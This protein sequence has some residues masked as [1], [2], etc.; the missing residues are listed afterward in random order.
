[1][2]QSQ[3]QRQ[4]QRQ[5]PHTRSQRQT[6]RQAGVQHLDGQHLG[7]QHLGGHAGAQGWISAQPRLLSTPRPQQ[8]PLPT[9]EA[10]QLTPL[11]ISPTP[12][13]QQHGQRPHLEQ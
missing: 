6:Q 7:G 8:I 11:Q 10:M 1:L 12:L 9:P 13:S 2:P 4:Q 3:L 5:R